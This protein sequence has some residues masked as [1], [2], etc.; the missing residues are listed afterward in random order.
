MALLEAHEIIIS[1]SSV[2]TK[3]TKKRK[4]VIISVQFIMFVYLNCK[5][6]KS[7]NDEYE[8]SIYIY[9]IMA[10]SEGT[11]GVACKPAQQ[12]CAT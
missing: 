2:V 9:Y 6:I 5:L 1:L 4:I 11:L 12:A 3:T 10:P 8:Y 7:E